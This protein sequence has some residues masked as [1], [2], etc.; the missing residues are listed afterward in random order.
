LL[1]LTK[2]LKNFDISFNTNN[3]HNKMISNTS[4]AQPYKETLAYMMSNKTG[5]LNPDSSF[6][7]KGITDVPLEN[8]NIKKIQKNMHKLRY[9]GKIDFDNSFS[10]MFNTGDVYDVKHVNE[11]TFR[12]D[13]NNDDLCYQKLFATMIRRNNINYC[14]GIKYITIVCNNGFVIRSHADYIEVTKNKKSNV[15]Y[16]DGRDYL[17]EKINR[18]NLYTLLTNPSVIKCR[19]CLDLEYGCDV[20]KEYEQRID[21]RY[22]EEYERMND[23][24]GCGENSGYLDEY[25]LCSGCRRNKKVKKVRRERMCDIEQRRNA[26]IEEHEK[27]ISFD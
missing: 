1:H 3:S 21:E 23:C 16:I 9:N 8:L 27:L 10:R 7:F 5:K 2:K 19:F 4:F 12:F 11:M 25:G 15:Y 20:C 13:K 26:E 18:K 24:D 14:N 6:S 22:D 17:S